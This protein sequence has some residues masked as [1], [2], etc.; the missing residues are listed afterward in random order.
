MSHCAICNTNT[1]TNNRE[2]TTVTPIVSKRCLDRVYIDLIDFTSQPED[3][4]EY[5]LQVKDYF[6]RMVWLYALREKSSGEV[7]RCMYIWFSLNSSLYTIYYNNRTE[8]Q[9]D[10][11][12]L[13]KNC[14]PL[15]P[16][17]R[18]RAYYLQS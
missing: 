5:I 6:S 9:G 17:I 16:V 13:V 14:N 15:I 2:P 3:G 12:D 18:G 11:D 8:F 1:N 10:F 7:A 4:Y